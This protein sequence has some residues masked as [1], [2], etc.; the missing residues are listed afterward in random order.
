[1]KQCVL[2]PGEENTHGLQRC[3]RWVV[4]EHC[5]SSEVV[6]RW[7]SLTAGRGRAHTHHPI[8]GKKRVVTQIMRS[9]EAA[10]QSLAWGG[11]RTALMCVQKKHQT[12][13][14]TWGL[15]LV[16]LCRWHTHVP[17][18][19]GIVENMLSLAILIE[20]ST[21]VRVLW[22]F[23]FLG[24]DFD[25]N[26]LLIEILI[27]PWNVDSWSQFQLPH[28]HTVCGCVPSALLAV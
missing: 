10:N 17:G 5:L 2:N 12:E 4:H 20:R 18:W 21:G 9:P 19:R 28:P 22:Y 27:N 25:L 23:Y 14:I 16:D 7:S 13:S 15:L 6:L 3:R 8:F 24:F 1:M 11:G 26:K